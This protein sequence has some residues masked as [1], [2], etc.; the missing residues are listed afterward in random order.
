MG[1][2]C[3][4]IPDAWIAILATMPYVDVLADLLDESSPMCG[5]RRNQYGDPRDRKMYDVIAAY[6][7]V[8]NVRRRQYPP[9]YVTAGLVGRENL[10]VWQ[11]SAPLA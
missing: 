7:P 9:M 2:V 1:V 3:N 6:S 5:I 8:D 4:M 10:K 11:R